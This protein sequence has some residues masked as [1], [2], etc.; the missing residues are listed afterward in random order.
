[1][2]Y[3]DVRV[4]CPFF[5]ARGKKRIECE[6]ITDDCKTV[7]RF[8]TVGKKHQHRQVFCE[9]MYKN[10]EVYRMLIQKYEE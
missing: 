1:M 7:L 6:G 2:L 8:N 3:E 4:L 9:R 10:C 5:V